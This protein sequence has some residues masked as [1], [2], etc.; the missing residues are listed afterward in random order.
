MQSTPP[1]G[2]SA[3]VS[4]DESPS[5]FVAFQ[6]VPDP[7]RAASVIYPLA[8]LLPLAVAAIL[9]NHTSVLAIAEWGQRQSA[10]VLAELGLP[11]GRAPWQST[12]QRV[13]AQ[14]DGHQLA[15]VLSAHVASLAAS[16]P[17]WTEPSGIAIDGKAQRGRL[18]F[19]PTGGTVHALSALC[20]DTGIVLAHEPLT[21]TGPKIEAELT[22]APDLIERL[23]WH[24]RVLTGDALFCQRALTQQIVAAGGDDLLLVRG[25]QPALQDA[26]QRLFDP[27]AAD[28][29]LLCHLSSSSML[30]TAWLL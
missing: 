21:T 26:I 10:D 19:D 7:R 12:V 6:S 9:A 20:H 15:A 22:V 16:D 24:Q 4:I 29:P 1:V 27:P 8:A 30:L 23:D 17:A 18:V 5:L 2:S 14:L 11:E 28:H 3:S 25:N 13:F